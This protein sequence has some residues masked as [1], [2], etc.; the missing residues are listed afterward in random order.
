MATKKGTSKIKLTPR[1]KSF[2]I[3]ASVT[4]NIAF[5]VVFVTMVATSAL[6]GM[7]MREGLVRYC[8]TANDKKFKDTTDQVKALREFTCARGEAADDFEAAIQAYLTSKGIN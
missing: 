8:A 4:F 2:F 1:W 3:A 6:D 7:I 5:V